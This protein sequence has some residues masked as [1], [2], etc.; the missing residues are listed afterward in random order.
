MSELPQFSEEDAEFL[1]NLGREMDRHF[2]LPEPTHNDLRERLDFL[3]LYFGTERRRLITDYL[4]DRL[5][6]SHCAEL[7]EQEENVRAL[8]ENTVNMMFKLDEPMYT[9][10][11]GIPVGR[12]AAL[13]RL[14]HLADM[15]QNDL[16]MLE[17][18]LPLRLHVR[19]LRE[20]IMKIVELSQGA[21]TEKTLQ[22]FDRHIW[23]TV[24]RFMEFGEGRP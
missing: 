5:D 6:I 4:S 23:S 24:P 10:I 17:G 9:N 3:N 7:T 16:N 2:E 22:F 20:E 13:I 19:D 14:F 11:D 1:T 21:R 8:F 15:S 18:G 12:E